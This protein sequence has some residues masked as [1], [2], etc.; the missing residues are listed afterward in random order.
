MPDGAPFSGEIDGH[1]VS[2]LNA[3]QLAGGE[4]L[5]LTEDIPPN[6]MFYSEGPGYDAL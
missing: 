6:Y 4:Q 5:D 3:K 1:E 2:L